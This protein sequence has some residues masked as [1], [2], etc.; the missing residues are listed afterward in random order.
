MGT[1]VQLKKYKRLCTVLGVYEDD[2]GVRYVW[3]KSAD[4][5]DNDILASWIVLSTDL[6]AYNP[7]Y[8]VVGELWKHDKDSRGCFQV[9]AVEPELNYWIMSEWGGEDK[10]SPDGFHRISKSTSFSGKEVFVGR[11]T[12]IRKYP[13]DKMVKAA[14]S[15]DRESE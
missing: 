2:Q 7:G 3:V 10:F 14:E 1:T 9:I 11:R 5:P 12:F 8:P 6:K 4:T 15:P 13:E